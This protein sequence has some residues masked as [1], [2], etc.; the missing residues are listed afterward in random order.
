M[1]PQ[2]KIIIL[3]QLNKNN[4]N[5]ISSSLWKMLLNMEEVTFPL[6]NMRFSPMRLSELTKHFHLFLTCS[7]TVLHVC[8]S[9]II[10][11]NKLNCPHTK[12][13]I[14]GRKNNEQKSRWRNAKL[15]SDID[16]NHMLQ[17][18]H[19]AEKYFFNSTEVGNWMW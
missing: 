7:F 12:L 6:Y 16:P 3:K 11:H 10:N 18:C 17:Q 9:F 19:Y 1:F 2:T 4:R 5:I 13:P 8:R 14:T 15:G